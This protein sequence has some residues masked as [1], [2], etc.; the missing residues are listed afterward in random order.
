[1]RPFGGVLGVL[2]CLGAAPGCAA[3]TSTDEGGSK[4]LTGEAMVCFPG[5]QVR[6]QCENGVLGVQ[7]CLA[8][9]TGFH[10]C[11]CEDKRW[12]RD[13]LCGNGACEDR[14][15]EHCHS[16][17]EDC[18]ACEPCDVAPA[19]EDAMIPPETMPHV[20]DFDVPKMQLIPP[21]RIRQ[22]LESHVAMATEGMRVVAAALDS[23][24][25]P[26]EHPLV[27]RLRRLFA[28]HPGAAAKVR[29]QLVAAGLDAP[30]LY[31]DS[32][33]ERAYQLHTPAEEQIAYGGEFPWPT[34]CGKPLLRV[35]VHRI[36]VHEEDD[37]I[38]NDIVYC[39]VQAEAVT[40]GEVRVTPKTPNLDEGD[41]HTFS[42]NSGVFWGQVEPSH[43]GSDLLLTYDCFEA[44]TNDG[45]SN[46]LFAIGE[47]SLGMGGVIPGDSGWVFTVVGLVSTIVGAALTL[48][49]DDYLFSATQTVPEERHLELTNGAYWTVRRD[50]THIL[51][52]W[53]WELYVRAWGCAE[54]GVL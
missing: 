53:D 7:R 40:G 46:L 25:R 16:C 28:D 51:S 12:D 30:A 48:D 23:H 8:D 18:G 4:W 43:P 5:R 50:G 26:G 22:Y 21:A 20:T 29:R 39:V 38:D 35:G 42:L 33:P 32:Y 52:D 49:G 27:P 14:R 54:F 37:D 10:P 36:V 44:D 17:P 47:A 9:G 6:C 2:V 45:Y 31:R 34:V 13:N 41:S 19:C 11:A 1:M 24:A 15:G 3:G